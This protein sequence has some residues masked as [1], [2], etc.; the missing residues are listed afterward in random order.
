MELYWRL[1]RRLKFVEEA[2]HAKPMQGLCPYMCSLLDLVNGHTLIFWT[3]MSENI[4]CTKW[5][6]GDLTQV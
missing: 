3:R 5:S 4:A 6:Q 2:L 1:R